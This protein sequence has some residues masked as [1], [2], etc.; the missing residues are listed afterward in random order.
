MTRG[1]LSGFL[2]AIRGF[3]AVLLHQHVLAVAAKD[4]SLAQ[5]TGG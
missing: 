5:A 2:G 1:V 3:F 4:V